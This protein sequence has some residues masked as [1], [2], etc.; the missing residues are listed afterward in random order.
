VS[1]FRR[2]S[3]EPVPDGAGIE[4]AT[5]RALEAWRAMLARCTWQRGP[6]LL[7]LDGPGKLAGGAPLWPVSQVLAAAI[8]VAAITGDQEPAEA[9]LRGLQR[10][11]TGDAFGPNPGDPNRYYDDNCWIALDLLRLF[12]ATGDREHFDA[13]RRLFGFIAEGEARDGGVWW[14][15]RPRNSRHTCSTAP[16]EQVA[17]RLFTATGDA[18]Y[19]DF[20]ARCDRFLDRHLLAP[21]GMYFDNIDNSG[22]VESTMWS[23]NQGVPLGADVLWYDLH[24]DDTRLDR[25]CRTAIASLEHYGAEGLWQQPAAFNG[26]FF[27]ELLAL[28]AH[29]PDQRYVDALDTYL[30]RAWESAR[31]PH[32][33]LLLGG[34]IGRYDGGGTIDHAALVQLF[35]VRGRLG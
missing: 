21:N 26:I 22:H 16:A 6:E 31:D 25:A 33:G 14:V 24:R 30:D 3:P 2:R 5:E 12:E 20:A 35:A 32:H 27:R 10:Y 7:V 13:S 15:E 1:W 19:E 11:R 18:T 4:T 17:L 9:L 34:G 8:D 23:Y 29:R 28:H